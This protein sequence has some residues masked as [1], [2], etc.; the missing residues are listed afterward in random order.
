MAEIFKFPYDACRRV[1][2]RK[3]R[4]SKN[5]TPEER[6]AKVPAK[7]PPAAVIEI[8]RRSEDRPAKVEPTFLEFVQTLRG[9]FAQE[10]ARG[11]RVDQ[12]FD[13]LEESYG[14]LDK[15]RPDRAP[16]SKAA[17]IKLEGQGEPST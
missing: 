14:R 9:Y 15:V 2:S 12:I 3:P 7:P 17:V 4:R 1:H 16:S 5:G 13:E 11:R 6:A 8:S 10:F